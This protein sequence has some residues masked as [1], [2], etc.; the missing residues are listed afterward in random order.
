MI[1]EFIIT[2]LLVIICFLLYKLYTLKYTTHKG[3]SES[4]DLIPKD[5][6]KSFENL[7]D[8]KAKEIQTKF[9]D[10]NFKISE[11]EKRLKKNEEVMKKL[12]EEIE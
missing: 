10:I 7:E 8:E 1:Y 5:I 11:L 2:L 9:D 6:K 4:N 12:I 3:I